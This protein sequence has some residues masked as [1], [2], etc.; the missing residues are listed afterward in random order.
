LRERTRFTSLPVF[1]SSGERSELVISADEVLIRSVTGE[2]IH[3]SSSDEY[4][5][6][7]VSIVVGE[8]GRSQVDSLDQ[9][10]EVSLRPKLMTRKPYS[11]GMG[12]MPD[13][14]W[15]PSTGGWY[16][17][18]LGGEEEAIFTVQPVRNSQNYWLT[19]SDSY[20]DTIY[21]SHMIQNYECGVLELQ[22]EWELNRSMNRFFGQEDPERARENALRM[23]KGSPP[24]W[25]EIVELTKG[26][27]IPD[28]QIGNDMRE[29][30]EPLIPISFP[31][32]VREELMAFLGWTTNREIPKV[33]PVD[34]FGGLNATPTLRA[35]IMGHIQCI[36]D[37]VEPPQYVR[38]MNLAEK[39]QLELP[40][41]PSPTC[42]SGTKYVQC[43]QVG[44][45]V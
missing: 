42:Y 32:D 2:V 7:K 40:D 33:D 14:F 21:E 31:S 38:L 16:G 27:V 44:M 22:E 6:A 5:T 9:K 26:V 24:P 34:F 17:R 8:D 20:S 23:L 45:V 39:R 43:F 15:P 36:I 29:S 41:R 18:V 28:L 19:I 10:T 3:A 35:L 25:E 4:F 12:Q 30:L 1:S 11:R 37:G 13:P